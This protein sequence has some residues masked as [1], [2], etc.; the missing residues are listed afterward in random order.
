[1][2]RPQTSAGDRTARANLMLAALAL[3]DVACLVNV[4][5]PASTGRTLVTLLA[6]LVLPGGAVL[7]LLPTVDLAQGAA[8]MVGLSL[9][10]EVAATLVMVWSGWW[11]PVEAATIMLD[12]VAV[13]LAVHWF[14]CV[15]GSR[16]VEA[17]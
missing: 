11:Y 6:A 14:R 13:A 2:A 1:M 16:A 10:I 15:T 7:T 12:T 9:T 5:M 8:L 4:F 17:Q 3:V